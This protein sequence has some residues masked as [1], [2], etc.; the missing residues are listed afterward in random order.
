MFLDIGVGVTK[1][2]MYDTKVLDEIL[3]KARREINE[4]LFSNLSKEF[5]KNFKR[6]LIAAREAIIKVQQY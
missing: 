4:A 1:K 2:N 3:E 6:D 5:D